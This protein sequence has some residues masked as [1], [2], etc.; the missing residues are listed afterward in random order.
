[1]PISLQEFKDYLQ[2]GTAAVP[3]SPA[4]GVCVVR[5]LLNPN[6][7]VDIPAQTKF[8][9]SS[10]L[11][12]FT[13][14]RFLVSESAAFLPITLQS[15]T[16]TSQANIPASGTSAWS[17]PVIGGISLENPMPFSG[18]VD[19]VPEVPGF[20]TSQKQRPS[21]QSLQRA[22]DLG[23]DKV[24]TMMWLTARDPDPF[25]KPG[26]KE[27]G[28]S[29][30]MAFL[31]NNLA[32]SYEIPTASLQSTNPQQQR[33]YRDKVMAAV[34]ARAHDLVSADRDPD[35]F[36]PDPD[37][38][39]DTGLTEQQVDQTILQMVSAGALRDPPGSLSQS[40]VE[41]RVQKL[42]RGD[43]LR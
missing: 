7:S 6:S 14:E 37:D 22:L 13:T 4:V 15:Q 31:Q 19:A 23:M 1:M 16:K 40:Q 2:I 18:G 36:M 34:I 26:P 11:T 28:L 41:G 5:K 29:I 17:S 30:S 33:F 10:G 43:A 27:A 9:H 12:F 42:V 8:S 25:D 38:P 3:G 20:Y 32:Q 24:R 39:E 21:D 35:R